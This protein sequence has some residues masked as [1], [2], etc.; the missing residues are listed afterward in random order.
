MPNAEKEKQKDSTIS[1]EMLF[2]RFP[3]KK[4]NSF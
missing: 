4:A 1:F 2:I 3:L